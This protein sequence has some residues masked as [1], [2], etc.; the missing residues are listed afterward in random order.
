MQGSLIK[1]F[2]SRLPMFIRPLSY[3]L[4][5]TPNLDTLS[6]KG[7]IKLIFQVTQETDFIVFHSKNI[8]ITSKTINEKLRVSRLLEYPE[9]DQIYFETDSSMKP[10]KMFS[11]RLKFQY[12]ISSSLEGFYLSTYIDKQ[13]QERWAEH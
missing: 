9:R 4:E 5:L 13:R 7:I 8:Q 10:G 2:I 12:N 11:I 1:L 6:V 3:D